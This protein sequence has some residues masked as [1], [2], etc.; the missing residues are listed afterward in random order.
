MVGR[1]SCSRGARQPDRTVKVQI[2]KECSLLSKNGRSRENKE[3]RKKVDKDQGNPSLFQKCIR[4][5]VFTSEIFIIKG[6]V[7]LI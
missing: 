4:S 1:Q 2:M 3:K 5:K 7:M 6:K